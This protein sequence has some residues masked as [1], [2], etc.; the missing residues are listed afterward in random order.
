MV[1]TVG[2]CAIDYVYS[3]QCVG[4]RKLKVHDTKTFAEHF[5]SMM[6]RKR[7]IY[8]IRADVRVGERTT[9]I[10]I[11]K[12]QTSHEKTLLKQQR[13]IANSHSPFETSDLKPVWCYLC[14]VTSGDTVDG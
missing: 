5:T 14:I 11:W 13:R 1:F 7:E 2:V 3:C 6:N 12:Y 10:C 4:E 9:F 8:S